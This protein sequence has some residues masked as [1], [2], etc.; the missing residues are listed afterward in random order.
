MSDNYHFT[1]LY[2]VKLNFVS[3]I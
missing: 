2:S 3:D 1:I